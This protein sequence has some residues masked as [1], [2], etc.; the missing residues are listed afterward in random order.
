MRTLLER[1][2]DYHSP[3]VTSYDWA[4]SSLEILIEGE[5]LGSGAFGTVY[6]GRWNGTK[7]AVKRLSKGTPRQVGSFT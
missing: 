1:Q 3:E 5:I 6:V 7:V 4:V 2:A